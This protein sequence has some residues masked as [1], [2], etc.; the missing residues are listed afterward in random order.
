M[1]FYLLFV[2]SAAATASFASVDL[3][4]IFVSSGGGIELTWV[5]Q[6]E[7]HNAGFWVGVRLNNYVRDSVWVAGAGN[8]DAPRRYSASLFLLPMPGIIYTY[9]L[10]S[11]D[12]A[13]IIAMRAGWFPA[14]PIPAETDS[15]VATVTEDGVLITAVTAWERPTLVTQC[16]ITRQLINSFLD[17]SIVWFD[18][19]GDSLNGST[20]QYV[21]TAVI[22][23]YTY[24]YN[25][26]S[27]IYYWNEWGIPSSVG[28]LL[29]TD[30]VS[31]PTLA[32]N[33]PVIPNP[34]TFAL[35]SF[36]NPFNPSTAIVYNLPSA[37]HISLRVFDLLGREVAV[38]KDGFVEAGT[39]RVTFDGSGLAS[40]IYFTRLDAG[41][42]L[43]TKRLM[44]LK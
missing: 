18:F 20:Y 5:T 26:M 17:S 25:F 7:T 33:C 11:Q 23:G 31:I 8:S 27:A 3:A 24:R 6:T 21:D 10:S 28:V 19:R 1:K 36:P 29:A 41:E 37:G 12:T 2:M 35:S 16:R 15:F 34:S 9:G 32:T 30:T 22:P 38:L 4:R 42:R 44:L 40:G 14:G 43:Q 39:H 13:G